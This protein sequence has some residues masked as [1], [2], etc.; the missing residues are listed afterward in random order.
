MMSDGHYNLYFWN[1][2]APFRSVIFLII[3]FWSFLGKYI[4]IYKEIA[5]KQ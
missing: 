1:V 4:F 5:Q 3:I 2:C